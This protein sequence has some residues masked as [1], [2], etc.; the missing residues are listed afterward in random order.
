MKIFAVVRER[1]TRKTNKINEVVARS[2]ASGM[3]NFVFV[4]HFEIQTVNSCIKFKN[5][6]SDHFDL[7]HPEIKFQIHRL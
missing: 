5:Y 6:R 2:D 4:L 1:K 3:Q 7:K